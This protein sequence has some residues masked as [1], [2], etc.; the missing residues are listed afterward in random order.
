M[1]CLVERKQK[2]ARETRY[3]FYARITKKALSLR[4]VDFGL[5]D[6]RSR[7]L[8][9]SHCTQCGKH[10]WWLRCDDALAAGRDR[11]GKCTGD[12]GQLSGENDE[13][14]RPSGQNKKE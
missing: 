3:K 6:I 2:E 9:T 4:L 1:T 10:S 14:K 13:A 12:R 7:H 11:N 8:R 5:T